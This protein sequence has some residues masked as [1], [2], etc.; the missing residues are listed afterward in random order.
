MTSVTLENKSPSKYSTREIFLLVFLV[1]LAGIIRIPSLTQPIGPD[2]GIMAVI[3]EGIL[4]GKLPYIDFWEMAS[5]AIFFTYALMFKIF[6]A[7]MAAIPI[8]DTFVAMLTTVLLYILGRLV[9]DKKTACLGALFFTFF[10][11]G[12]LIGMHSAGDIAFGT[13][14]YICQ[15]ESFML[16]LIVGSFY[17]AFSYL[18]IKDS[19]WKLFVSGLLGGLTFSFKFPSIIFFAA[20]VLYINWN[21]FSVY[22]KKGFVD[23]IISNFLLI[24]GFILAL[25]PFILFFIHNGAMQEMI[26]IIFKYVYSVY[27][28]IEH[29]ML[30]TLKLGV[31]RTLFLS[32]E[33]FIL[34]LFFFS[35]SIYILSN[36]RSKEN[37]FLVVWALISLIYLISH[38][39][40]FGYHYL[41]LFP[42]FSL[43]TA[44]GFTK[45]F[46]SHFDLRLIFSKD[47]GKAII[48]FTFLANIV[49]FMAIN[50]PHYVKFIYYMTGKIT[51]NQYYEYFNAYPKHDYS[52]PA[53][54]QVSQ[55]IINNSKADDMIYVLGGI[56]SCI[57][58]L[59]KRPS[60][61]RFIFSW[62]LF[63]YAHGN[64]EKA[65]DYRQ[66][67]FEDL[68]SKTPK[69]I[70]TVRSLD[71]FKPFSQIYCFIND[72][73][74]LKK[75]FSDDRYLYVYNKDLSENKYLRETI[76]EDS[77]Y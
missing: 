59:T 55:Y 44:Y 31:S 72:N 43:L 24:S 54:Y 5:P 46:G 10:S 4:H 73:Y 21:L 36:D 47:L 69:Y 8:T 3:G 39:E 70:I 42:S 37:I 67:L 49:S 62:I 15:R 33:N 65:K 51:K 2:Q 75:A 12:I 16:P 74:S 53:D 66:E 64:V 9:W 14:W 38:K 57:Y 23:L 68:F 13:F 48:I 63:Y 20:I 40:F 76:H 6:G 77:S 41:L 26:D 71:T 32:K 25:I 17:L 22:H 45:L 60:P 30:W 19:Y 34:W 35:S 27:G 11:N 1:L 18:K 52:F 7:N 28:Q 61:S 50:N 56:E 58:F 29:K